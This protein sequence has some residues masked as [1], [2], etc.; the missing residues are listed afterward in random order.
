[1]CITILNNK[2]G[3]MCADA[4]YFHTIFSSEHAL[5]NLIG[6]DRS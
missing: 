1:M 2:T 3:S 6:F 4:A 5:E